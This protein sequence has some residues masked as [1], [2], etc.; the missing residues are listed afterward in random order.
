MTSKSLLLFMGALALTMTSCE[1][2]N[3][4]E[5]NATARQASMTTAVAAAPIDNLTPCAH[6]ELLAGQRY[7]AGDIKVYF[8][9]DNLYVEYQASINWHLRKTH[10]YV[11]DQRLIPL[12]RLG[13]PNV[14]FFPIQQTLSEGTQTVMYTFPKNNLRK[15]FIISAYAEVYKTDSS[16]E[17]VQVESAWSTGERFNEDS[18]GMYF[19]VCQ[20]DCS[21]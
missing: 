3:V 1:T 7:D 17:I 2:E 10:L 15:C 11:G 20:S 19:D 16:G 14:E 18:W 4:S 21:N 5:T 9:Q 13:N 6:S 8:D 12:T